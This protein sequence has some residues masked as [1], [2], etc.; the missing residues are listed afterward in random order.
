MKKNTFL[1][2]LFIVGLFFISCNE[3]DDI[4]QLRSRLTITPEQGVENFINEI[5]NSKISTSIDSE[6]EGSLNSYLVPII[7]SVEGK[8]DVVGVLSRNE[9]NFIEEDSINARRFFFPAANFELKNISHM[10]FKE[11]SLIL[12]N[13]IN[14]EPLYE[15]SLEPFFR[16]ENK[17]DG[18]FNVDLAGQSISERV[19]NSKIILFRN[20]NGS[21]FIGQAFNR[22]NIIIYALDKVVEETPEEEE[23]PVEETPSEEA[24]DEEEVPVEET[25]SEETPEEEEVPVEETPI[26]E[27]P[28]EEEVPVEEIPS[29]E[30]PEEEEVP[31]EETPSEETPEEEEVPVEEMPSEETPEEEEV[32]VEETPSEETPEEEEVPVEEIPSEETPEEEEVNDRDGRTLVFNLDDVAGRW[33]IDQKIEDSFPTSINEFDGNDLLF[34]SPSREQFIND[35]TPPLAGLET[36]SNFIEFKSSLNVLELYINNELIEDYSIIESSRGAFKVEIKEGTFST[37]T[38]RLSSD[39]SKLYFNQV[40][41]NEEFK[42]NK[43]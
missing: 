36:N 31:V 6:E 21:L 20:N 37:F 14:Q 43:I 10:A 28:E 17:V 8:W 2:V 42:F 19:T 26:E 29:E 4:E 38:L 16:G 7:D 3:D 27:T 1:K 35:I 33:K 32:P 12:F 39:K 15:F 18:L 9:E 11:N 13:D 22:I 23:V 5:R 41:T 34:P 40:T 25:P 24:P 30:T